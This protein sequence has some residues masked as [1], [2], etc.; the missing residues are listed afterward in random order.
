[1]VLTELAVILWRTKTD[2]RVIRGQNAYATVASI[3]GQQRR[4]GC[5]GLDSDAQR[6]ISDGLLDGI[7]DV[8]MSWKYGKFD[9]FRC[10]PIG[11]IFQEAIGQ[12]GSSVERRVITHVLIFAERTLRQPV[13]SA[14]FHT[15][16]IEAEKITRTITERG[17]G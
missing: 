3:R 1:M 17:Q 15:Y 10:S 6:R 12:N 4:C 8:Q 7:V 11:K 5:I 16:A 2:D 14:T 9:P 13:A